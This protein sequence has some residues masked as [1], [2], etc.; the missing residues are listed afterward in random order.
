[1]VCV[2]VCV[3]QMVM[4]R[5]TSGNLRCIL[6]YMDFKERVQGDDS[7]EESDGGSSSQNSPSTLP[8]EDGPQG[9]ESSFV[10]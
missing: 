2:C 8:D 6:D 5:T 7:D 9:Y 1:M 10:T 3:F 4:V